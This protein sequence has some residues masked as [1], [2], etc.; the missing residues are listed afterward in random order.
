VI[1]GLIGG[2]AGSAILGAGLGAL[3]GTAA[4]PTRPIPL[5]TA[6]V[7]FIASRGLTFGGMERRAWYLVR[8]VFG[9]G[10]AYFY[11]DAE[12]AADRA[13]YQNVDALDDALYDVAI[14]KIDALVRA[15]AL[16]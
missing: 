5:E 9:R 2:P 15:Y 16:G 13:L 1:G 3:A 10:A 6:L 7:E 11:I 14:A 12:V 4:N 8:V